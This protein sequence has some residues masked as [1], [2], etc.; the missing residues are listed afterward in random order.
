MPSAA[1]RFETFIRSWKDVSRYAPSEL[2]DG[3]L[4]FLQIRI[5]LF[6][7]DRLNIGN[8]SLSRGK[9]HRFWTCRELVAQS[10]QFIVDI[11]P[12]LKSSN[13]CPIP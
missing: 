8:L 5:E 9:R 3:T 10:R 11:I 4:Q 7:F 2:V 1:R 6:H 13:S 12:T